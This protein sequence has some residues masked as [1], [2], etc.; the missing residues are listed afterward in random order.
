VRD[1]RENQHPKREFS[2]WIRFLQHNLSAGIYLKKTRFQWV[3]HT[4][5]GVIC[6]AKILARPAPRIF[7]HLLR[8]D[9]PEEFHPEQE[10]A[11]KRG[12][13]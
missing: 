13:W 7:S 3:E 1:R 2:V 8:D 9:A 6:Q 4:K 11:I 10:K 5:N 12:Y